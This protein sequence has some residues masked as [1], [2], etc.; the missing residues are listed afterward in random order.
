MSQERILYNI[1]LR[2][3]VSLGEDSRRVMKSED[4]FLKKS[5]R[6]VVLSVETLL[7]VGCIF[8]QDFLFHFCVVTWG[9]SGFRV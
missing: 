9:F 6:S 5:R 4:F 1:H 3:P 8:V 2:R 7:T